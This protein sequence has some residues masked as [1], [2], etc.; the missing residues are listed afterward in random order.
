MHGEAVR[1][2]KA[3]AGLVRAGGTG[4]TELVDMREDP[5]AQG[6]EQPATARFRTLFE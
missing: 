1:F 6:A 5:L 2:E 3:R 4:Q